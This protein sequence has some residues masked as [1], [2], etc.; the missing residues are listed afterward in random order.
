MLESYKRTGKPLLVRM[1]SKIGW[2]F[3]IDETK[4]IDS[5]KFG[6]LELLERYTA[7]YLRSNRISQEGSDY[8]TSDLY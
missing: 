8:L 5:L 3:N 2:K 1:D 4:N 6:T 7:G